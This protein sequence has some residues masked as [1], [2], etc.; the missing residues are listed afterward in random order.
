MVRDVQLSSSQVYLSPSVGRSSLIYHDFLFFFHRGLHALQGGE[1]GSWSLFERG[2]QSHTVCDRPV[3]VTIIHS[4]LF[5]LTS[6]NTHLNKLSASIRCVTTACSSSTSTGTAWSSITRYVIL[7]FQMHVSHHWPFDA[8]YACLF[9][10]ILPRIINTV[11]SR[12]VHST[13]ACLKS[14]CVSSLLKKQCFSPFGSNALYLVHHIGPCEEH[15]RYA[16]GPNTDT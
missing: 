10:L 4:V 3:R 15:S 1:Q 14:L 16:H 7:F 8:L 2:P 13:S 6:G 5:T 12:S 9:T 11:A